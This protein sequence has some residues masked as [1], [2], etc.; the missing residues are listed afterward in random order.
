[1]IPVG[2]QQEDINN[3][4]TIIITS[5]RAPIDSD[6][7]NNDI[8]LIGRDEDI[9]VQTVAVVEQTTPIPKI[10]IL[11]IFIIMLC[12]AINAVSIYPYV[13]FMVKSFNLT[14]NEKVLGYYVGVLASSYYASQL[15]SSF[16]WGWFSNRY[17]RRPAVLC[18]LVGAMVSLFGFGISRH[19]GMAIFFRFT[20]GL[21]NGNVSVAKTMLSEITDS[22][23]QARAFSFI[24]LS[25]SIGGIV[26]PLIG[27]VTSNIC[28][29]SKISINP[30]SIV[31]QYPYLLPNLICIALSMIG[32]ILAIIYLQETISFKINT[33]KKKSGGVVAGLK[34]L[35]SKISGWKPTHQPLVENEVGSVNEDDGLG[36]LKKISSMDMDIF[37]LEELER[38]ELEDDLDDSDDDYSEGPR[39][40]WELIKDKPVLYSC[41]IYALL[42]FMFTIFDE[43][44]PLYSAITRSVNPDTGKLEGGGYGFTSVNIGLIQSCSGLFALFI[45][46]FIFPP[47]VRKTG[48]VN[49]FKLSM[50][51]VLPSWILLPSLSNMT[52]L[53]YGE[54]EVQHTTL[55]WCLLFPSYMFQAFAGEI[56]FISII[57][58][59]SNSALPKD[60]ALV[61]SI[62]MFLVSISR[63]LGPTIGSSILAFSLSHDFPFPLDYRFIFVLQFIFCVGILLLAHFVLP[64]TLNHTKEKSILLSEYNIKKEISEKDLKELDSNKI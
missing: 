41:V 48:L 46:T 61:N 37:G 18:G 31:C 19:Y 58:M 60:I 4:S 51:I 52:V 42:G 55:F 17:G 20:S 35:W 14:E 9:E 16:F 10:K 44:F 11:A 33:K 28:S 30:S 23:N 50:I 64:L 13:N 5:E 38:N 15:F 1:M 40:V 7:A 25:W 32:L 63:T 56:S 12:D 26:A 54:T 6:G 34:S 24:G 22:S 21:L 62:G 8:Q 43:C 36:N 45:Q 29:Q 39:S 57:I 27:G 53:Q 47:M 3:T 59:I 49:A 2:N